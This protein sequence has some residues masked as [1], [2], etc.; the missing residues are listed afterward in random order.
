MKNIFNEFLDENSSTVLTVSFLFCYPGYG[1]FF[2]KRKNAFILS[3][4]WFQILIHKGDLIQYCSEKMHS[5][6]NKEVINKN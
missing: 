5:I 4:N 2:L 3:L 1:F 6:I